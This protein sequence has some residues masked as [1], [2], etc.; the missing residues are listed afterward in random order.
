MTHNS[1]DLIQN[2]LT[3]TITFA[4]KFKAGC[5]TSPQT[6]LGFWKS[7][8]RWMNF[9][10]LTLLIT[11][12]SVPYNF[13]H[14]ILQHHF[15]I[16]NSGRNLPHF[17][18]TIKSNLAGSMCKA[19]SIWTCSMLLLNYSIQRRPEPQNS[20]DNQ[21]LS[22][23]FSLGLLIYLC[24]MTSPNSAKFMDFNILILIL[25]N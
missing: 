19:L 10:I 7:K 8:Q 22:N 21:V 9:L 14:V 16:Y 20:A 24:I 6:G 18:E 15:P 17:P 5:L 11:C 3:S 25:R 12:K 2:S 1:F 4:T 13:K 23:S